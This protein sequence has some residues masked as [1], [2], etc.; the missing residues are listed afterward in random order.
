MSWWRNLFGGD[1]AHSV[2]SEVRRVQQRMRGGVIPGLVVTLHGVA[3]G[4]AALASACD[5]G[6][7]EPAS[8]PGSTVRADV[9]RAMERYVAA[10][11]AAD[12]DSI[13]AHFAPAALLLEPGIAPILRAHAIR[14]APSS[15]RSTAASWTPPAS[16][17]DTIQV[18]EG[19]AIYWGAY[20]ERATF[21]GQPESSQHGMLV[22]DWIQQDDGT[23]LMQRLLRVPLITV[24]RDGREIPLDLNHYRYARMHPVTNRH[25]RTPSVLVLDRDSPPGFGTLLTSMLVPRVDDERI[26]LFYNRWWNGDALIPPG[27]LDDFI[28]DTCRRAGYEPQFRKT[29]FDSSAGGPWEIRPSEL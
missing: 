11:R 23:W 16:R 25:S 26:V 10:V 24:G 18:L 4:V 5:G 3:L 20:F 28:R 29:M 15:R 8:P 13:S 6:G 19:S 2:V 17:P 22:A 7:R 12:P 1:R 27:Q 14:S 21:P 9:T